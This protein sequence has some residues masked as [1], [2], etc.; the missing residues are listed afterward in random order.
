MEYF[1][2]VTEPNQLNNFLRSGKDRIFVFRFFCCEFINLKIQ[3]NNVTML[4]DVASSIV[5]QKGYRSIVSFSLLN[6]GYSSAKDNRIHDTPIYHTIQ[7][8]H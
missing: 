3:N 2:F 6:V 4:N 1:T 8:Q 7:Y 5:S